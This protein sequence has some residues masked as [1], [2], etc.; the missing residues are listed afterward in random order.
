MVIRQLQVERR[1]GKV[2]RPKTDVLPLCR[3]TQPTNCR[4]YFLVLFST[5]SILGLITAIARC[6]LLLQTEQRGLLSVYLLVTFVGPVETAEP[7]EMP[8]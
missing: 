2:R 5:S 6:G 8:L 4:C 3:A 7:I 1:T